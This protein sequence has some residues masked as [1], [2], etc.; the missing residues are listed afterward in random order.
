MKVSLFFL[1]MLVQLSLAKAL[2]AEPPTPQADSL[3]AYNIDKSAIS[4]S[5]VS[6]GGFMAVQLGVAFSKDFASV[7]SV[8]GGIYWCAEGDSQKAQTWCMKQPNNIQS[9]VQVNEV[10]KLAQTGVVDPVANMQRQ[11]V[12]IFASPK[13]AVIHPG[14]GEKLEEFY[15]AFIPTSQILVEKSVEAAHGFPTLTAGNP[16][17]MGFLPWLLKCNF[18]LAGEIL[19]SA[20]GTLQERGVAD[21]KHL[22]KFSQ[23]DF[24][25]ETTPLYREGW[26]YVPSNCQQ[27][28]KCRLHIALHGCQMNPD[29]IQDKFATLAGYNDWAETN[30]IIVLYPQSAKVSKDNPYACW[31]WFGFTGADYMTKSGKQMQAL[32]KMLQ[33]IAP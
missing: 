17:Q 32:K 3:K 4:V 11:K 24:G 23:K 15:R 33:T 25:D 20:Y 9:E 29:F 2:Q 10:R 21:V 6:S 16:C 5:G 27:G 1:V 18:D 22:H 19:K 31:D 8:A 26:V 7:A 12:Y 28:E 30:N 14:N 13:D